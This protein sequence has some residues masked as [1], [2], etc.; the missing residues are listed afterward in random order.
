MTQKA[1]HFNR[2]LEGG[3]TVWYLSGV[4]CSNSGCPKLTTAFEWTFS[5]T[6]T[7]NKATNHLFRWGWTSSKKAEKWPWS[8]PGVTMEALLNMHTRIWL[9]GS[10][11]GVPTLLWT[12][13]LVKY[14]FSWY[15]GIIEGEG[16]M[17][18]CSQLW[19][20]WGWSWI[21][22]VIWIRLHHARSCYWGHRLDLRWEWGCNLLILNYL[23]GACKVWLKEWG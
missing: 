16:V 3:D 2:R 7:W 18:I 8:E 13:Q 19:Y 20:V 21:V 22:L 17:A 14:V 23:Y 10:D 6:S 4:C 11:G 1:Y 5:F 9:I 15:V 12:S